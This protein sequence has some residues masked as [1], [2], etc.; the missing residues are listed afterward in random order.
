MAETLDY[1]SE[2]PLPRRNRIPTWAAALI[3]LLVL[4][5][6]T[7]WVYKMAFATKDK[8]TADVIPMDDGFYGRGGYGRRGNGGQPGRSLLQIWGFGNYPEGVTRQPSGAVVARQGE[9]YVRGYLAAKGGYNIT[10]DYLSRSQ[11]VTPEQYQLHML[12]RDDSNYAR[13]GLKDDQKTKLAAL[14]YAV[15]LTAPEHKELAGL[16][17]QW[18]SIKD[19]SAK[20]AV[21]SSLLAATTK[22]GAAHLAEAKA[23]MVKRVEGIQQ[24][25]TTQQIAQ[26]RS[27]VQAGR[28]NASPRPTPPPGGQKRNTPAQPPAPATPATPAK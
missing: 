2:K 19:P 20:T 7:W 8:S 13:I 14:T 3:I 5:G 11:W 10:L 6:G 26:L 17:Q 16:V 25:L 27:G 23:A 15:T 28:N 4:G 9:V 21:T 18:D 1:E 24:I 22:A 12:L